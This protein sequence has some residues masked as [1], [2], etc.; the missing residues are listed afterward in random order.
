M[1]HISVTPPT[2]PHGR[3]E[4]AFPVWRENFHR[5]FKFDVE[6]NPCIPTFGANLGHTTVI[7]DKNF[8]SKALEGWRESLAKEYTGTYRQMVS[9]L[10]FSAFNSST[11]RWT[12]LTWC[13][14]PNLT[15]G[16]LRGFFFFVSSEI[17]TL[18][19]YW[20]YLCLM[21]SFSAIT[22]GLS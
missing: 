16:N 15:R 4:N 10:C 21:A 11:R 19:P 14:I 7:V 22:A 18:F 6:V 1:L 20:A 17:C 5:S 3:F 12:G 13:R 8:R 2:T 9:E